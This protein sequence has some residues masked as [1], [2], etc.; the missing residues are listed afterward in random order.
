MTRP[1]IIPLL[2]LLS[3]PAL[4]V[5]LP[6]PRPAGLTPP[7]LPEPRP[8]ALG[9]STARSKPDQAK[10]VPVPTPAPEV[11]AAE[12]EELNVEEAT[13]PT[14]PIPDPDCDVLAESGEAE[15]KLLPRITEGVCGSLSPIKLIALTPKNGQRVKLEP[16]ITTRCAVGAAMVTW[17]KAIRAAGVDPPFRRAY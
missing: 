13:E 2:C 10:R 14:E 7:Q 17:L 3:C 8:K 1:L 9:K 6:E 11:A 15:F 5:P 12:A 4:A 16:P